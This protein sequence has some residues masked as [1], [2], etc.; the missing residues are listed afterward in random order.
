MALTE[1]VA[2]VTGASRRERPKARHRK[3]Q[4]AKSQRGQRPDSFGTELI[5]Y[6]FQAHPVD[7][8]ERH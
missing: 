5:P 4:T 2:L 7:E 8:D 1:K 3:A 6:Q